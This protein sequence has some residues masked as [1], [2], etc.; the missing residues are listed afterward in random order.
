MYVRSF[1]V[2]YNIFF[3]FPVSGSDCLCVRGFSCVCVRVL[4]MNVCVCFVPGNGCV[5]AYFRIIDVRTV[6]RFACPCV[7]VCTARRLMKVNGLC[8]DF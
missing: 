7:R 4:R 5:C 3:L 6:R 1:A 8:T 2:I